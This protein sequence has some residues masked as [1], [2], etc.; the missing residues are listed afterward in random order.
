MHYDVIGFGVTLAGQGTAALG[1]QVGMKHAGRMLAACH[2]SQHAY[3]GN[4]LNKK[5]VDG[6][7]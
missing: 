5:T 3:G 6:G 4:C 1:S 2:R 7:V